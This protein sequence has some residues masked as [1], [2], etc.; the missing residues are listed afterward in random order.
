M[1]QIGRVGGDV[2]FTRGPATASWSDDN[3][4]LSGHLQATTA[5]NAKVLRQQILGYANNPDEPCIPIIWPFDTDVTGFY[6][7]QGV[8]VDLM[9]E[10]D[11]I[12]AF[13]LD[14]RRVH[15]YQAPLMEEWSA[16]HVRTNEHTITSATTTPWIGIPDSAESVGPLPSD[17][18]SESRTGDGSASVLYIDGGT[19]TTETHFF[20][21][22]TGFYV[23][24]ANF[25]ESAAAVKVGGSVVV[26]T[27]IVNDADG[28]EVGTPHC[29]VTPGTGAE[30]IVSIH[31]GSAWRA[32]GYEIVEEAATDNELA[33]PLAVSVLRNS[34]SACVIRLRFDVP[35]AVFPG[36]G[37]L[38]ITVR[39][40]SFQAECLWSSTVSANWN[41]RRTAAEASTTTSA[42]GGV[43]AS[44]DDGNGDRYCI[45]TPVAFTNYTEGSAGGIC[46]TAAATEL[47][48]GVGLATSPSGSAPTSTTQGLGNQYFAAMATRLNV[49]VA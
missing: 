15:G 47:P 23:S 35:A 10:K 48:F 19:S 25:Y 6:E 46:A 24:P 38:D 32:K 31:D 36:S 45:H 1:I 44:A 42:T 41:V 8:D 21:A 33:A 18:R 7:V 49:T 3:L 29:K 2:T 4:T 34:P 12:F 20:D 11:T 37:N 22:V 30:F 27:Q 16:G 43:R 28:W 5:A 14:L 26:G 40:G 17:V 13:T 9:Q 39:R